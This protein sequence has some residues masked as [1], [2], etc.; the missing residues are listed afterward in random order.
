MEQK[1]Q[2]KY[3]LLEKI[4]FF[5]SKLNPKSQEKISETQN[6]TSQNQNT[7]NIQNTSPQKY[8]T[9]LNDLNKQMA[10]SL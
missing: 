8:R 6:K 7:Q 9:F 5:N 2:S 1:T 4:I 3:I 10:L